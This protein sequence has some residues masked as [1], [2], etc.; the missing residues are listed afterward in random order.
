MAHFYAT[1]EG[2]RGQVS[3]MGTANSGIISYTASWEGSVRV[4]LRH[5]PDTGVDE[6]L[7]SLEPWQGRGTSRVLYDGPVGGG[8]V[9]R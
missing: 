2:N 5:N 9:K 7:V 1:I 8:G 3:R 4:Q 6:A